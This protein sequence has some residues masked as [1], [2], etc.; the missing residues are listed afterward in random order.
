MLKAIKASLGSFAYLFWTYFFNSILMK[1][2]I[3]YLMEGN[4]AGTEALIAKYEKPYRLD[5]SRIYRIMCHRALQ[6]GNKKV[7]ISLAFQG[8]QK[9]PFHPSNYLGIFRILM[10]RMN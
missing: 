3:Y 1:I 10:G 5:P 8:I 2:P 9:N 7:A 6:E 4:Q